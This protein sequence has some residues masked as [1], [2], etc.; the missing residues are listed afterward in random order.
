MFNT[1]GETSG[2]EIRKQDRRIRLTKQTMLKTTVKENVLQ[3][4]HDLPAD[5]TFEDVME[6]IYFLYKVEMGLNQIEMGA[7]IPHD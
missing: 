5:I 1:M 2:L 3:A 6:R 4:I 7:G